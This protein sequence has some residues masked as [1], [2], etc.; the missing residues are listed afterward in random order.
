MAQLTT[1]NAAIKPKL[2]KAQAEA[3]SPSRA[4]VIGDLVASCDP[5]EVWERISPDQ[6]RAVVA[7]LV[8]VKIMP[9][10]HGP[11]FDPDA[12]KITWRRS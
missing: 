10:H 8:D 1:I 9:T 4:K 3:A 7:L 6:R 5:R 12:I 2:E 11:P